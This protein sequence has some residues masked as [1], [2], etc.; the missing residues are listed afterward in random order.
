MTINPK[1]WATVRKSTGKLVR[2]FDSREAAREHK[3][4]NDYRLR[5]LDTATGTY[6]R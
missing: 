3:R 5:I 2:M 4:L 6:V 1:R